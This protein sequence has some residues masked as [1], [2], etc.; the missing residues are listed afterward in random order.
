MTPGLPSLSATISFLI[1]SK[2]ESLEIRVMATS[3][4][5]SGWILILPVTIPWYMFAPTEF[6]CYRG[7]QKV[8]L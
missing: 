1:S 8:L 2:K 4:V 3:S 7:S 6:G 5:H